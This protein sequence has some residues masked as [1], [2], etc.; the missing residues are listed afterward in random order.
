MDDYISSARDC[1]RFLWP[2]LARGSRLYTHEARSYELIYGITDHSWWQKTFNQ[3]PPLLIGA[4]YGHGPGA[5]GLAFM[6]K[7]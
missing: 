2:K 5:T 4:G 7:R 1:F 6:E 3:C